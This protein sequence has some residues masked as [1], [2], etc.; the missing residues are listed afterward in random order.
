[1]NDNF[2]CWK[3]TSIFPVYEIIR[4][5]SAHD[6]CNKLGHDGNSLNFLVL[7]LPC[8]YLCSEREVMM[9]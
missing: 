3:K 7:G 6:R 2:C 8:V 5:G 4:L 1:M 9:T